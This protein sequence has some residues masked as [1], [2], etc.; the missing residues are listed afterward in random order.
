[1]KKIS[2]LIWTVWIAVTLSACTAVEEKVVFDESKAYELLKAQVE[3]GDRSPESGNSRKA[4]ALIK[5][6]LKPYCTKVY[7]ERFNANVDGREIPMVNII[8]LINPEAEEWILICSHWDNRPFSDMEKDLEKK[9]KYCPGANDGASS[10]AVLMEMTRVFSKNKPKVGLIF[11]FFDGEDFGEGDDRMFLG[12]KYFSS[13]IAE[14]SVYKGKKKNIKF[15]ILLDMV[16]DSSLDIYVEKISNTFASEV[17]DGIWNTAK[18]L[19]Y[20]KYF[21]PEVKYA[22]SDDHIPLNNAGIPTVDIIDFDYEYWHTTEDT[23]DKCSA[24]SLKIVG[25][26]V[27]NFIYKQE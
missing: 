14:H 17:V 4:I 2:V 9:K 5:E 1:M 12:S 25:N 6:N 8:G 26:T 27:L 7:E 10:T 16:G 22:I 13:K 20:E 3:I 18:Q 15:G 23:V 19:G 11:V 24:E 21:I